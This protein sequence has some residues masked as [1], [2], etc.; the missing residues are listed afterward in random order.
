MQPGDV[1]TGIADVTVAS[2]EDLISYLTTQ[3][4]PGQTV[5]LQAL[6]NGQVQGLDVTISGLPMA[7]LTQATGDTATPSDAI[8]FAEEAAIDTGL[9]QAIDSVSLNAES[10]GGQS[11]W[12][13]VLAGT[14]GQ[15]T[16]A[17]V[18]IDDGTVLN[19]I[20]EPQ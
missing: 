15:Q 12:V 20:V 14:N 17:V 5:P 18:D 2:F 9:I 19:L 6:R 10:L 7:Q 1:I 3:T 16:T 13:V 8:T 11:V 4:Q